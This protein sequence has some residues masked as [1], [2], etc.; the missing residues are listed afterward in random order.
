MFNTKKTIMEEERDV[1]E[2]WKERITDE[3]QHGDIKAATKKAGSTNTTFHN[4]MKKNRLIELSDK[5]LETLESV[6]ERLNARK[7]RYEKIRA[8]YAII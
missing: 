5:E 2:I 1:L 6:I 7:D 8:K 4:A 3:I